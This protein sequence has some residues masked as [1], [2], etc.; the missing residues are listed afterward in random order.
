MARKPRGRSYGY[1]TLK[2]L[3]SVWRLAGMPSGKYLAVT[4]GLWLPKLETFGELDARRLTPAVRAQLLTV[5][6][7]TIDRLL[8]PTKDADRPKGLS[9]TK[10]GPLLRNSITVRKAGDEHEQAPGFIEADMVVHC[11]PTLAGE[12]ARTLT[13]TDVFTGWTE[14]VAVRNGAHKW[15]LEAM[16]EVVSRLPFPLVGLDTD[17]GG[18]FINY[19]LIRWAGERDI[20]FTRSRPYKSNDNAHVEQKNGDVV[21]RHAFHYRYDTAAELQLLNALYALVRVRL[22]LFTATTKAT[23]WRSNKHGKKTRVYD[24]PRTPYQR[25]IDSG[26]LTEAKA[27]ELAQLMETT[28]PADLTRGITKIQT[29]LIALAAAKTQ[30]LEASSTRAQIDEARE[31]ISRA[32]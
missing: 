26:I 1:D 8:K 32:S 29:Q 9:A 11:G 21:R 7:A 14:N 24:K 27:A 30:A 2:V 13:A 12:F 16:D 31:L 22:N 6:G 15:V 23:G 17:N 19:A 20:Y 28:N 10:A 25:V 5:S 18:E 3:I 4:M